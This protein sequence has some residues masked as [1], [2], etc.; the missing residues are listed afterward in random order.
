MHNKKK[1]FELQP[2]GEMRKKYYRPDE[3]PLVL[4]LSSENVPEPLR[5][6]IPIAE[7]WGISDDILRL[8]A[9]RK[10]S[11]KEI[12]ELQEIVKQ[13]DDLLDD[14]LAGREASSPNPTAEYLAFS[15]MRMAADGC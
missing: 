3:E 6:L 10:A 9:V 7:R 11:P 1:P 13:F 2:V 5:D 14:W 15:N 4:K 8:D 12:Q